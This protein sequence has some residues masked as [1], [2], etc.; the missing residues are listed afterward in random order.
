MASTFSGGGGGLHLR[1]SHENDEGAEHRPFVIY[2]KTI[3]MYAH[4][5][6]SC[7]SQL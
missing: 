1:R 7:C 2:K 5:N 3:K 4:P 6:L